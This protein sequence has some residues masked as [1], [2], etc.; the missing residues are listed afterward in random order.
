MG[1]AAGGDDENVAKFIAI[2][3]QVEAEWGHM[4]ES[5]FGA[6]LIA[7]IDEAVDQED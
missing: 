7:A 3:E 1:Y 4:L 5:A 6:S 2:A